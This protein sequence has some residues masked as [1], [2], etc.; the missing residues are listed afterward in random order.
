VDRGSQR[1]EKKTN[2][3]QSR[4]MHAWMKD[5]NKIKA[6]QRSPEFIDYLFKKT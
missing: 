4:E 6:R 2:G 1:Q 5:K 3:P